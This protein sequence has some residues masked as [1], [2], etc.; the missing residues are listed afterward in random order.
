M[1]LSA[2]FPTF[3]S[4]DQAR[5][6]SSM[7]NLEQW[8]APVGSGAEE[9][10]GAE[11]AEFDRELQMMAELLLDIYLDKQRQHARKKRPEY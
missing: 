3:L 4:G 7:D 9:C 1:S 2:T 11:S 6:L 5:R 10:G 8:E